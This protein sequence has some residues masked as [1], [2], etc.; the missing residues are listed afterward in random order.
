MAPYSGEIADEF[1]DLYTK[2]GLK[3]SLYQFSKLI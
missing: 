1:N 2:I 3:K